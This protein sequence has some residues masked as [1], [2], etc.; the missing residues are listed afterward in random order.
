MSTPRHEVTKSPRDTRIPSEPVDIVNQ[1]EW[2]GEYRDL[3]RNQYRTCYH[4]MIL[5]R[6]VAVKSTKP[7]GY[8]GHV[9]NVGAD[10]LFKNTLFG[11]AQEQLKTDEHRQ[12][13]ADFEY[14]LSGLPVHTMNPR[15]ARYYKTAKTLPKGRV[16]PPWAVEAADNRLSYRKN[17]DHLL[18]QLATPRY[19]PLKPPF[20]TKVTTST[21]KATAAEDTVLLSEAP[22]KVAIEETLTIPAPAPAPTEQRAFTPRAVNR[23]AATTAAME[24]PSLEDSAQ[25]AHYIAQTKASY[26]LNDGSRTPRGMAAT[27]TGFMSKSGAMTAR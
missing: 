13:L 16:I 3:T 8:G 15:G 5:Q 23:V 27:A 9:A 12:R 21:P 20:E 2:H 10:V 6:E 7:S 25:R 17:V 4:D 24:P 19:M 14:Q 11:E 18:S 26:V 22:K 1:K